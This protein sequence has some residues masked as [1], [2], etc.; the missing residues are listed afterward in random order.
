MEKLNSIIDIEKIINCK[1]D[2]D[3]EIGINSVGYSIIKNKIVG[4]GLSNFKINNIQFLTKF[5]DLQVLTLY[6]NE[7]ENIDVL[8]NHI[9]LTELYLSNNK[10]CDISAL[11]NLKNLTTLYLNT[12]Q[13]QDIS[14]LHN[15][16]QLTILVLGGNQIQDISVLKNF[17][18][19][20]TLSLYDNLIQNINVIDNLINLT[21]LILLDN[22][23]ENITA[24]QNL[25]NI[26][27]LY[28]AGNKIENILALQNLKNLKWLDLRAN[29]I[30]IL[31]E[32]IVDFPKLEILWEDSCPE[33]FVSI[34]GNPIEN[35]PIEILKKGKIITKAWINSQKRLISSNTSNEILIE[36]NEIQ[37]NTKNIRNL[38]INGLTDDEF[39]MLC[40]DDFY[41]VYNN[42]SFGQ[43][44]LQQV[45]MLLEY[46]L[47]RK[48]ED[49]L[50]EVLQE[51]NI[52][53]FEKYKPYGV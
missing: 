52:T 34:Y 10:I 35:I 8:K 23:I 1:L 51:T 3:D 18:S 32:W 42:F 44:R 49:K 25:K 9:N 11:K 27:K 36:N 48:M 39:K 7:V 43:N 53:M 12:N 41:D 45:N 16:N 22:H 31:P 33:N 6:D 50:L 15:L 4:L 40:M 5:P 37:Y 24:L 21:D 19:L 14:V 30:K 46:V 28:L 20:T 29:N 26:S 2:R 38:I 13:I 17:R 47:K